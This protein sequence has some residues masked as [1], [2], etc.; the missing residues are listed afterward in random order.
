MLAE[1][2]ELACERRR[3]KSPVSLNIMKDHESLH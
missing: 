3:R 1:H 2:A